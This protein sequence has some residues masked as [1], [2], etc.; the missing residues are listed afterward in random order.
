[1]PD[2]AELVVKH[3][4]SN[5]RHMSTV[6]DLIANQRQAIYGLLE[7]VKDA[8]GVDREKINKI[9]KILDEFDVQAALKG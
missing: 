5:G 2:M 7:A 3:V 4:Q 8:P 9:V 6:I 1:M